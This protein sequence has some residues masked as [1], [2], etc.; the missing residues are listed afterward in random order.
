MAV[1][2]VGG[3]PV[4]SSG[5]LL[6]GNLLKGDP[7]SEM[8]KYVNLFL[9]S[10]RS[11]LVEN[12][13]LAEKF[14]LLEMRDEEV[15]DIEDIVG[16]LSHVLSLSI[17][18]T[19]RVIK[20]TL[21]LT[22]QESYFKG[23]DSFFSLLEQQLKSTEPLEAIALFRVMKAQDIERSDDLEL[24]KRICASIEK[25]PGIDDFAKEELIEGLL[26]RIKKSRAE[27][28]EEYCNCVQSI[29][30]MD[31]QKPSR[32]VNYS[33]LFV[34]QL[35]AASGPCS[36]KNKKNF[37]FLLDF[38]KRFENQIDRA[39]ED[40]HETRKKI[41]D[42]KIALM[43]RIYEDRIKRFYEFITCFSFKIDYDH[44]DKIKENPGGIFG[45][46][47]KAALDVMIGFFENKRLAEC[48]VFFDEDAQKYN[49]DFLLFFLK[50]RGSKAD[51]LMRMQSLFD[52]ESKLSPTFLEDIVSIIFAICVTRLEEIIK[53]KDVVQTVPYLQTLE[54]LFK[55]ILRRHIKQ[56]VVYVPVAADAVL[57]NFKKL[58]DFEKDSE[59]SKVGLSMFKLLIEI[60]GF[61]ERINNRSI[62]QVLEKEISS[63]SGKITKLQT[64][65]GG[66]FLHERFAVV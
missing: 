39:N 63:L 29:L 64:R 16:C 61:L 53:S 66:F 57:F 22:C 62:D 18:K 24:M 56:N 50:E 36:D 58:F 48:S 6:T 38:I 10:Q 28:F 31:W 7:V 65:L 17:D 54:K 51:D 46:F 14:R 59:I 20:K 27:S 30:S 33:F 37:I 19:K 1:S 21:S 4:S 9:A 34:D 47:R 8:K 26:S 32:K 55:I 44:C 40:F 41:V 25:N 2:R 12:K 43:F 3:C 35:H 13:T 45:V 60:E 52:E 5:N 11:C 49:K 42:I 15:G 23:Y